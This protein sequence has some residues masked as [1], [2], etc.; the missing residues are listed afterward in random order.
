M[1]IKLSPGAKYQFTPEHIS[2]HPS[3]N[4]FAYSNNDTSNAHT[5]IFCLFVLKT[6]IIDN[7]KRFSTKASLVDDKECD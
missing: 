2:G 3:F 5:T 4:V 1:I 7:G 6:Q